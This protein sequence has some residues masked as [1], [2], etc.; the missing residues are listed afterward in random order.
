MSI[1]GCNEILAHITVSVILIY[2]SCR[3]A[4]ILA[5]TVAF[6]LMITIL[7]VQKSKNIVI[8]L[9][10]AAKFCFSASYTANLVLNS[11]LFPS[12][13]RN[14]AFGTSLVMAQIGTM[15]AP[16]IVDLL[17]VVAWWAPTTLCSILALIAGFLCLIIPQKKQIQKSDTIADKQTTVVGSNS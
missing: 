15:T 9:A 17:G 4:N 12:I 3:H 11:E 6:I 5:Y 8:G 13:V 14:T 1:V 7:A 2:F 16:Y 10:L